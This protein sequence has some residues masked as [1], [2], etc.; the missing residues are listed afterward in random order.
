MSEN[1]I[2]LSSYRQGASEERWFGQINEGRMGRDRVWV[3]YEQNKLIQYL[4]NIDLSQVTLWNPFPKQPT[5]WGHWMLKGVLEE[6][7]GKLLGIAFAEAMIGKPWPV[8]WD[9]FRFVACMGTFA[10]FSRYYG[11]LYPRLQREPGLD[12]GK[13]AMEWQPSGRKLGKTERLAV[14]KTPSD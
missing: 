10:A 13:V 12:W 6:C 7:P 11:R 2:D 5:H 4:E 3:S 9:D 14:L 1:L 8:A